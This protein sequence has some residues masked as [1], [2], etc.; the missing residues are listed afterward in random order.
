V[1]ESALALGCCDICPERAVFGNQRELALHRLTCEGWQE[2][3]LVL[4][5][6]TESALS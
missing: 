1:S 6:A 2:F 4:A 3:L 5:G